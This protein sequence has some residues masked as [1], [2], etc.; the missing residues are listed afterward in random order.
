MSWMRLRPW[1]CFGGEL[2]LIDFVCHVLLLY[3]EL[4]V[5]RAGTCT[6]LMTG[7]SDCMAELMMELCG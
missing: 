7:E 3:A 4:M 2:L 1:V 6:S 5:S